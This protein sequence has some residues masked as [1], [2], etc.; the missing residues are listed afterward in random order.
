MKKLKI[1]EKETK[2]G[3]L[4]WIKNEDYKKIIL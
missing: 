2:K 1:R 3:D 4:L